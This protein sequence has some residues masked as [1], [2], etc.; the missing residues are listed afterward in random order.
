MTPKY[1]APKIALS[2][3]CPWCGAH[4]HQV[5]YNTFGSKINGKRLPLVP[6][7]AE[8][9]LQ[10]DNLRSKDKELAQRMRAFLDK[11]CAG[12]TFIDGEIKEIRGQDLA[13][14]YLAEC[15][16]C[17][18]LSVW[19]YDRLIHP[20]HTYEIHPNDDLSDD[21]K[22]DFVE[23]AK[24]LQISPRGAAA[25]LRLCIQKICKILGE[26]GKNLNADIASLVRKG[27]DDTI[28]KA[29]DVV[30]VIG[31]EAVHPG[32]IDLRDDRE[33]AGAL[34]SLVNV[35]A[36]TMITR[37]KRIK[38]IFSNLPQSKRDDIQRRD[39]TSTSISTSSD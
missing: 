32:Q 20:S 21:I 16:S 35:I 30:R 29:L 28:Q 13:N 27:M 9:F 38:D 17:L 12:G 26:P 24:I 8:H 10:S 34:F 23:A 19:V 31:N 22:L 3:N 36:E 33:T 15:F 11:L 18:K 2:F 39:D 25:L 6:V 37:P 14:L 7:T 4:A 5:W 1:V